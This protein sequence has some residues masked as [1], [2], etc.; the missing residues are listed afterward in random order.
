MKSPAPCIV[1]PGAHAAELAETL[2][3]ALPA[4]IRAA[5]A[6][7]AEVMREVFSEGRPLIALC[8]AGIVIRALSPLLADKRAEPPVLAVSADGAHVVPLLGGHAG[9]NRLAQRIA[10]ITGGVAAITTASETLLGVAFDDPP[11]GWRLAN[12]EDVRPFA[13]AV[14]RGA[15]VRLEGK[16]PWL[17]RSGAPLSEDGELR[18][19]VTE[20][21]LHGS[22]R[23]LVCHPA[24]LCLGAGLSRGAPAKELSELARKTLAEAGLSPLAVAAVGSAEIKADEP[25][26]AAL[27]EEFGA[28]LRFFPP[29]RLAE[30]EVPN[31]SGIVLRA[32]GAPSVA[33]AAALALCGP[34]GR[35]IV[36]KRKSAN[37][38][39]AIALAAEPLLDPPG[40]ARG[41]LFVVG[42]GPGA[43]Q[44]R[45]PQASAALR[46]ADEWV[47]YRLYLELAGDLAR[48]KRL[49]S[50]ALGQE[51]ERARRAIAL[52]AE[53]RDVALLCSGDAAIYAMAGLVHEL[54]A[55]E[56]RAAR[57]AVEVI[58]G[59]SALQ[60]ASARAGALIGH[61]FCAISLSDLLTPWET[62][63]RRIEAAA[64]GDFVVA[65][66]N[67]RSRRRTAQLESALEI[68]RAAR[69]ADVPAVIAANL[70][71]K[72]EKVRVLPLSELDP[73]D[74]D[75]LSIVLIG[76][77]E[78]R[79]LRRG[80]GPARAYTPRGYGR[81]GKDADG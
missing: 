8:A 57:I 55:E 67:P 20:K 38:T 74:I 25:A 79:I 40:R 41:R 18:F 33:E 45:T 30:M 21:A 50:F 1:A 7:P 60:A 27:A 54:L 47:G 6:A 10:W 36:E 70:G 59:V 46:T 44:M 22:P 72:G 71:R 80:G 64:R 77:S 12:P 3:E 15:A 4:E 31:P 68:L 58:P 37:A 39:C 49:H 19:T 2:A 28:P 81:K 24:R 62:I 53:G 34:G 14:L 13:A 42:L 51:E 5:D 48:G 78:S 56:A 23:H 73:R 69:P 17:L 16:A 63:R 61:D 43:P 76:A 52:A 11:E 9:A 66:Y 26:L 35:L 75:M 29:E 32:T 65:L